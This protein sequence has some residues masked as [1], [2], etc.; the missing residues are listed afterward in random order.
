MGQKRG[1]LRGG[2]LRG[3][4]ADYGGRIY[5]MNDE[6]DFEAD[7]ARYSEYEAW[8]FWYREPGDDDE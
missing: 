4:R 6:P 5:S 8:E 7:E 2:P 1:P 3:G